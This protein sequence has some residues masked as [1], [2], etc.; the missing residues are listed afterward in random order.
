MSQGWPAKLCNFCCVH[1]TLEQGQPRRPEPVAPPQ[2]V[3]VRVFPPQVFPNKICLDHV[4][5]GKPRSIRYRMVYRSTV[6]VNTVPYGSPVGAVI[7]FP[8]TTKK[9]VFDL[10]TRADHIVLYQKNIEAVCSSEAEPP[11]NPADRNKTL[12]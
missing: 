7:I 8:G 1:P 6:F 11:R 10:P 3:P 5:L 4:F 2:I 9:S 12:L